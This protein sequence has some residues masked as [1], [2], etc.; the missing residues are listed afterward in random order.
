MKASVRPSFFIDPLKEFS[1]QA[2]LDFKEV[3]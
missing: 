2:T 1:S 3:G